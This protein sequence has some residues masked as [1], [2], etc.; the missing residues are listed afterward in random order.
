MSPE[1]NVHK[2]LLSQL[3]VCH[4]KQM[5]IKYYSELIK[6]MSP[7]IKYYSESIKRMSPETNVHKVLLS[8]LNVCH[9]KQMCI[10]YSSVN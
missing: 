1:T 4:Q 5:C 9:Q 7:E 10:K 6:R 3:N 8:Q 2:V